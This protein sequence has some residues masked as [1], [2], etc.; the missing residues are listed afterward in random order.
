MDN[1]EQLA[2]L[3]NDAICTRMLQMLQISIGFVSGVVQNLYKAQLNFKK[4]NYCYY[5]YLRLS[6]CV[7][8][9]DNIEQLARLYNDALCTRMLQMLQI[10]CGFVSGVVQKLYKAQL[11]FKKLNYCYYSYLRLSECVTILDNIEQLARLY[12]DAICTRMLQ[13]LQITC[14]FVS[15]VVQ[16]LY[17]AQLNFKKLN[18]CYYSYLRLSECVTIMDNIEQLARLYNDAICTG[19]LQMLQITCGF[20]SGVVQKLY[21]A[22][23]N[24][25]KLNYCYYNYLRLSECLTIMDNNEQLARL[26]NDAICTRMLQMLQITCGFF[27]G[28]VQNLYKAQLNF[29]K[30][31][32]C[33][34]SYL[35]LSECVTIMDNIEQLARLYNDT[36]CTRMLQMLQITCG[37][38]SGVV[39]KLYKAQLNFNKLNYCYYSYLR[40]SECVTIMDNIEQ[41]AWLYNDAICTRMLQMLQITCAFVS[42]VVQKLYKAQ[43]NFKKLNYCYYSY[44]RLSECET[45]MDNI[46]QLAR[47]YNDGICTRM[48]Q[49]LQ[50]TCVF[51]SGVVQKLYKAQLNFEK[52]NYCYYCYLRLSECVTIMDNIE[53]LAR[54]YNDAIC[55]RMLQMLQITCGFVSGVVQKLYKAQLNFKKLNYCYYSYLRLSECVTIM[56]NIEQLARLYNDAICTRMLQMLQI[57][58]GFVSGV[59]QK[60]YKAQLNFEK[61]NYCYYSYIRLS[62]RVTT[63]DNNEQLPRVYIHAICIRMV[64][65]LQITCGFVSGVVDNQ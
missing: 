57:T 32:Y 63:M 25:K 6:E 3:Y 46:E 55:T 37:F 2:R 62:E 8:I 51:V 19:M 13:M 49:M 44:L 21:K 26:Y 36:L 15:G 7:T 12:N 28:V 54:L 14:G 47:L 45:I 59:V 4:L 34:Y 60:L 27:S 11:N 41:L 38:V 30:L 40:L 58:C 22:Q 18:Y 33:Y 29:K 5:S 53:Q 31:N 56:D 9:M 23:L 48:L 17:K 52:L 24:F 39:Q 43:L 50:I 64:Q 20:V 10:T 35:R 61:L 1:N 16:K 42:G 65:M